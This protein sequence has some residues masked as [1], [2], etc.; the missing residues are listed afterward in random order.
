MKNRMMV[1]MTPVTSFLN[2]AETW[3]TDFGTFVGDAGY[4]ALLPVIKLVWLAN[5]Q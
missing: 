4:K 3:V 2:E 5:E 1:P